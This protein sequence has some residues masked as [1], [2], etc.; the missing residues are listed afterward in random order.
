MSEQIKGKLEYI[1]VSKI[2][3]NPAA[4]REVDQSTEKWAEFVSNIRNVGVL[5][6]IL[7]CE[8]KDEATGE[9]V[10]VLSDGLH[11]FTAAKAAGLSEIPANIMP[12]EE[13]KVLETQ[14]MLNLHVVETKPIE[15]S[16]GI[17]RMLGLNPTMTMND[18][19]NKLNVNIGWLNQRLSLLKLKDEYQQLVTEGKIGLTNA[20]ALAKLPPEEQPNF[21]DR[22]QTDDPAVFVQTANE[23]AKAIRDAAR[24]G[25]DAGSEQ[26]VA[27]PHAKKVAELKSEYETGAI[28]QAFKNKGLIA[29]TDDFKRGIEWALH[30]DPMSVEAARTEW[31]TKQKDKEAKNRQKLQE[32]AQKKQKEAEEILQN[33][34]ATSGT[35]AQ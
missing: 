21:V 12:L 34:A 26:F 15:F 18:M 23:R 32:A 20:Y 13:A 9:T 14:I 17:I 11:R 4:L 33:L 29:N 6:P 8:K 7:V 19:C 30:L 31:E 1:P 2:H 27:T 3:E 10:Y 16:K 35:A 5:K 25:K 24:K 28:A 22:A